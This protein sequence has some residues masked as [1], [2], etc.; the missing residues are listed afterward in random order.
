M[1]KWLCSLLFCQSTCPSSLSDSSPAICHVCFCLSFIQP[2]FRYPILPLSLG[3]ESHA[4][5]CFSSVENLGSQCGPEALSLP[6]LF[7]KQAMSL[8][9]DPNNLPLYWDSQTKASNIDNEQRAP[10]GW[11]VDCSAAPSSH[12]TQEQKMLARPPWYPVRA[13]GIFQAPAP[14]HLTPLRPA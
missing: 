8:Q 7:W 4:P 3:M 12:K 1:R 10:L 5:G 6:K 2:L 11:H 13:L 14:L 9:E